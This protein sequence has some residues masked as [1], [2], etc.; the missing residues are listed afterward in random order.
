MP[1]PARNDRARRAGDRGLHAGALHPLPQ[2]TVK[3]AKELGDTS[4]G[5]KKVMAGMS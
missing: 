3:T 2:A 5:S 1:G 4:V